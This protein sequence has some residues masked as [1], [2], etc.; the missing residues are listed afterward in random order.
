ML[1][2]RERRKAVGMTQKELAETV[3]ISKTYLC[4]IELGKKENPGVALLC[5]LAQALGVSVDELLMDKAG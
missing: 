5:K 3:N 2:I 1:T 4:E